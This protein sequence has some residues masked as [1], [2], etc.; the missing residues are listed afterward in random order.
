MKKYVNTSE[1]FSADRAG[2]PVYIHVG[3]NHVPLHCHSELELLLVFRGALTVGVGNDSIELKKGQL[4]LLNSEVLHSVA[5]SDGA[6]FGYID[7]SDEFVAPFGSDISVKYIKP[8]VS[9]NAS[10][11]V[12]M[13]GS[14]LWH[15]EVQPLAERIFSLMLKYT[16][17]VYTAVELDL[18]EVES[19]CYELD[20]HCLAAE[21]WRIFCNNHGVNSRRMQSGNGYVVR[22]R[23]QLM[24][25]FIR[26]NYRA[27]ITLED[28]ASSA[29]ISKSEASRCFQ[30][31]LHV[32]PVNYLLRYRVEM[33]AKLLLNSTMTIEAVSLECG[34]GSAS[35]FCKIFRQHA[36]ITPGE[37]RKGARGEKS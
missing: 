18:P 35:Y 1:L 6:L 29:N 24:T 4:L 14:L 30:S 16:A 22:R 32:S 19:S 25:D 7:L 37:Y 20:V 11:Y 12:R 26:Q 5:C 10:E 2:F 21:F 8:F 17:N 31:C 23:A 33:A 15:K 28:I 9:D 36:G 13:D 34:F 27:D 3:E